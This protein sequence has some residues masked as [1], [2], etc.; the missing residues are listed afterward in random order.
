MNTPGSAFCLLWTA[1]AL[2]AS[3]AS[4]PPAARLARSLTPGQIA[5]A[6]TNAPS[7]ATVSVPSS[8]VPGWAP[9]RSYAAGQ[10]CLSGGSVYVCIQ[11]HMSTDGVGPAARQVQWKAV[12][13]VRPDDTDTGKRGIRASKNKK[14]VTIWKRF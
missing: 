11:S 12:G 7:G 8:S 6:V 9:N 13:G 2:S 1:L 10:M 3:S 5:G 4:V 14:A